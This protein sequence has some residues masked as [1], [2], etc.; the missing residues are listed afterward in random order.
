MNNHTE[1]QKTIPSKNRQEEAYDFVSQTFIKLLERD[2]RIAYEHKRSVIAF[3]ED[4]FAHEG[5]RNNMIQAFSNF[6]FEIDDRMS[7]ARKAGMMQVH[8]AVEKAA[9]SQT[10][11]KKLTPEMLLMLID[12]LVIGEGAPEETIPDVATTDL[13]EVG[14][15][16][17]DDTPLL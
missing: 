12:G 16:N 2:N 8:Y 5:V 17:E 10:L 4:L 9:A 6:M 13:S 7:A 3:W 1:E 14:G 11:N 15:G